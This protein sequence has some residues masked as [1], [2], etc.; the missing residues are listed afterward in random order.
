[1]SH[2]GTFRHPTP[3]H[4]RTY[5]LFTAN[6]FGLKSLGI[7]KESGAIALDAGERI[8]LRYRFL[9]HRGNEQQ[10]DIASAFAGYAESAPAAPGS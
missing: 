7:Q 1:M 6:P 5:G 4:V 2:P 8:T 10:A 3:W 9:F